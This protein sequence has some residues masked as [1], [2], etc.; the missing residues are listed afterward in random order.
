MRLGPFSAHI[1]DAIGINFHRAFLYARLSYGLSIPASVGLIL[2]EV[3]I[4]P[5]AWYYDLADLKWRSVGLSL[6]EKDFID[7][8]ETPSFKDKATDI[9]RGEFEILPVWK[10]RKEISFYQKSNQWH[11]AYGFIEAKRIEIEE[12]GIHKKMPLVFHFLESVHRANAL[13]ILSFKDSPSKVT[14][15]AFLHY[16]DWF[17]YWQLLGLEGAMLLDFIAWP[18]RKKGLLIYEQDVPKIPVP[19]I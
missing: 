8:K 7:M 16:R 19:K 17:I 9:P 4:L 12:R 10:W 3:F 1:L 11:Q 14:E 18:L 5:L 2:F 6:L 13:T 15:K